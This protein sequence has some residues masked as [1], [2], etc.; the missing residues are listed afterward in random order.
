MES[1]LKRMKR[2]IRRETNNRVRDAARAIAE[3]AR[4]NAPVD[5]GKLRSEIKA[6]RQS[7]GHWFV[8]CGDAWYAHLVEMGTTH[9]AAQPFLVPASEREGAR[10]P[11]RFEDLV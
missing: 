7:Q 6:K 2:L 5:T 4:A 9:S 10:L 3:D 8:D 11:K 1:D